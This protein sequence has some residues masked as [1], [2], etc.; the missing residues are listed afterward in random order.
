MTKPLICQL[1]DRGVLRLGGDD[2]RSFLQGLI[3]NDIALCQPGKPIYAALLTPQGK[4]LHDMFAIDNGDDFLIDCESVRADDLLKRLRAHKLRAKVTFENVSNAFAVWASWSGDTPKD[5]YTDP[6]LSTLGSR[7]LLKI[8][9]TPDA[10][11]ADF[12]TYDRH[13]LSL[14][15]P[16][17]SRDLVV[18]K[19]TLVEGNLD[20][21]NAISW[22]KGC[23]MKEVSQRPVQSLLYTAKM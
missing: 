5:F 4:F 11:V 20:L 3:S 8:D 13:R 19:S 9:L 15:V 16:D 2:R 6:R 17:G 1:P 7:A 23:Y 14:G 12:K 18:E 21:L 22:T 10:E